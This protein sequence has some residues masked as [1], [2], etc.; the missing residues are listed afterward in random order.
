MGACFR[1][2]HST[3]SGWSRARDDSEQSERIAVTRACSDDEMFHGTY[4]AALPVQSDM[5]TRDAPLYFAS[6]RRGRVTPVDTAG[7]SRHIESDVR[8][9]DWYIGE[10]RPVT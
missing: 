3:R 1:A 8:S 2:A 6:G 5:T 7:L 9:Q 4:F 10:A